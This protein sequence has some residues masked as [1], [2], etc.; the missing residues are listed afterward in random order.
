MQMDGNRSKLRTLDI[1]VSGGF[2][3]RH[4]MV[5]VYLNVNTT[6]PT[7]GGRV[8]VYVCNANKLNTRY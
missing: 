3:T 8:A 2:L 4:V 7:C 5:L 1:V 6:D